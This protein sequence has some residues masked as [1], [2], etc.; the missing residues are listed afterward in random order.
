MEASAL[1]KKAR[2][3]FHLTF[4]KCTGSYNEY[5]TTYSMLKTWLPFFKVV[6]EYN[7]WSHFEATTKLLKRRIL[8]KYLH[9]GFKN[10]RVNINAHV[11]SSACYNSHS[12]F[13]AGTIQVWQ[14]FCCNC[15]QLL[16]CHLPNF[17]PLRIFGP[18]LHS[19]IIN[20][21]GI[22]LHR[23]LTI[24]KAITI[25][26]SNQATHNASQEQLQWQLIYAP[27]YNIANS[28]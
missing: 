26:K 16:Y 27:M 15:A 10:G 9:L 8:H 1:L 25:S 2:K 14:L 22:L 11:S 4:R 28:D 6:P 17:L 19:C 13:Y 21:L 5:S 20:Q 12:W 24:P 23:H 3:S 18:F 7:C